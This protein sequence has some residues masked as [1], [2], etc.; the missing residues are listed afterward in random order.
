V[1]NRITI[2]KCPS[3][4]TTTKNYRFWG[5]CRSF[6]SVGF[7]PLSLCSYPC[8]SLSLFHFAIS[9]SLAFIYLFLS[10]SAIL[11][12]S[13][14]LSLSLII[15]SCLS[16]ILA[17]SHSLSLFSLFRCLCFYVLFPLPLCLSVSFFRRNNAK[18]IESYRSKFR[19]IIPIS[20]S[21]YFKISLQPNTQNITNSL[22]LFLSY[23]F[24][25]F[26]ILSLI[27]FSNF[28]FI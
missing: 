11:L 25:P 4:S 9:S 10:I 22:I 1:R 8:L 13:V 27:S 2:F 15:F 6:K 17:P 14:S 5:C 21:L 20:F 3:Y 23:Y 24:S 16:A 26:L 19:F 18:R 7:L 28:L 12:V